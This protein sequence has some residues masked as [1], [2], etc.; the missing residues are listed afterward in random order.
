M[1]TT[2]NPSLL[3][4]VMMTLFMTSFRAAAADFE[5]A[6]EAVQRMGLGW[7]L[8]NTL[9][10]NSQKVTDVGDA[11]YWGQQDLS[12]E[13]CW[14]QYVTQPELMKMMKDAGFGAIRVPVT[15]YNHMD[16]DGKVD[17]AWMARVHEVVDYVMDEGLYCIINV[18]HDTGADGSS[19][20]SWLKADE[21]NYQQN[22]ARYE[23]LWRQIAEEFK[24]YGERLLFESYNEMLDKYS[25]W[26]YASYSSPNRYDATDATSA[27]NAIN[28]YAQSFVNT[29]R[30]T[31]GN[32]TQR[33]LI[34][35][36]YAAANGY[37]GWNAHLAE[38]LTKLTKPAG[39][40]SHIA[41]EVH[42]YPSIVNNGKDRP[43]ADIKSEVDG[44]IQ[45][46]KETLGREGVPAIIGEWGTSNVDA[47]ETDYVKRP[48]LMKQFCQ[49]FVEKC[50]ANGIA[51]FYWMGLSDGAARLFPAFSQADLA[52]WL[53]EAYHGSD[54]SAVLPERSD[55]GESCISS[56]V[57]FNQQW[58]EFNL[59]VGSF[60][61][62]DYTQLILELEEVPA[63]GLLDVKI[64]GSSNKN[65]H[66]TGSRS[67]IPFTASM[68]T[69]TRVTLQCMQPSGSARVENIWLVK[70]TGEKVPSD[71]SVFWGCTMHDVS[72]S[73][74]TG[75]SAP[76]IPERS[77]LAPIY[78]LLGQ[79]QY[80]H[81]KKG[82]YI[83]DGKKGIIAP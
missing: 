72:I 60:T 1:K 66:I 56:T 64:Y 35:N 63:T 49:Y 5:T 80:G 42:A 18:H 27:Y 54:Y 37:G 52:R 78:N 4:A 77:S 46:L 2:F 21:A 44:M 74:P 12:S 9:E 57:D 61:V 73:W 58:S 14:G 24:G 31:G 51:A 75:V 48:A 10:A 28:S 82:I 40:S 45:L 76:L 13:T 20:K 83:K 30:A 71:P 11:A 69:I 67:T 36:T 17:P 6:T 3:G 43:I 15:W 70:K 65:I 81:L 79:P 16:I 38:P 19:F 59:T 23:G 62:N 53:L 32:N 22:R 25:S 55:Y 26:C 41:F 33:N 50:K 7:N 39:E 47:A 68:G 29:V 8:G 34:V